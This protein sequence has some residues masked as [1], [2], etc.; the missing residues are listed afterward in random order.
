MSNTNLITEK[1]LYQLKSQVL[2]LL[3]DL[4]TIFPNEAD[5]LLIRLFFENQIEPSKLMDGFIKW[6]YPWKEHILEHNEEFFEKN[7]HIFGPLPTDKIRYLKQKIHD[8]TIDNED[9]QVMWR[10]F[11]IFIKLIDQYNKIK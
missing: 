3:D 5:L 7:E 8:G 1:I 4:L 6:V 11:E 9:K 2:N 10:Y